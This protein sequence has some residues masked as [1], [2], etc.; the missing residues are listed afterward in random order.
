MR[1]TF[2]L[3]NFHLPLSHASLDGYKREDPDTARELC[4]WEVAC[5][6]GLSVLESPEPNAPLAAAAILISF[7]VYARPGALCGL[8][9]RS[10]ISLDQKRLCLVFFLADWK[11]RSKGQTQDDTVEIGVGGREWLQDVAKVVSAMR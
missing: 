7:L 9:C 1:F 10:L 6:A 8:Q 4:T 3:Q 5:L 11:E 2:D